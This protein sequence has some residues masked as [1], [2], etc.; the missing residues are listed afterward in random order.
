MMVLSG[1]TLSNDAFDDRITIYDFRY[2]EAPTHTRIVLDIEKNYEFSL[3]K[4]TNTLILSIPNAKLLTRTYKHLF[5]KDSR[6][7]KVK[8]LRSGKMLN[9]SYKLHGDF[10]YKTLELKPSG[11]Y[12]NHR[13]VIDI[14][15]NKSIPKPNVRTHIDKK[16]IVL[17][18]GHGGE[19]S[20]A[21]G[22]VGK[23][24]EKHINLQIAKRLQAKI[25]KHPKLHAI[26]TRDGDY[27]VKLSSRPKLAQENKA[28]LFISI[29]ADSA[30]RIT[31][32]G[33]SVY[34]LSKKGAT[35]ELTKQLEQSANA[36][37]VFEDT[38]DLIKNDKVLSKNMW[39]LA[40]QNSK[41]ESAKFAELV[42]KHIGSKTKI[43]KKHPG[44][45]NFVV[46]KTPAIASVLF[47]SA[48]L[49]NERDEKLLNTAEYQNKIANGLYNAIEE[50]FRE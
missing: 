7:Q 42:L 39:D 19:D 44:K 26:L 12:P 22:R 5:Y 28:D 29:H 18:P 14:T 9:I 13:L 48:F 25:N 2:Y 34:I 38:E 49:S 36:T 1:I 11:R 24:Y 45:A 32:S 21:V 46:L 10:G 30:H 47:E 33:A 37:D 20:G 8:V 40:Q 3:H 27:Y 16:I 23:T 31:A 50:Y 6:V 43:H 17:D 41:V 15:D 4:A 35:T